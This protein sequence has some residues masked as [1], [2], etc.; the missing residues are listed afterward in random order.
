MTKR[1][2][3]PAP[4]RCSEQTDSREVARTAFI[5]MNQ[6]RGM[7]HAN[8]ELVLKEGLQVQNFYTT[9]PWTETDV[10][11]HVASGG[12]FDFERTD[13]EDKGT[14]EFAHAAQATHSQ[15]MG[16]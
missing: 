12:W 8:N 6:E 15:L 13:F 4:Y 2:T 10:L 9:R 1:L 7:R 5:L 3:F 14:R 11:R 16:N